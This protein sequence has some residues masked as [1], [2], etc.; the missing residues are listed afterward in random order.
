[1]GPPR[2]STGVDYTLSLVNCPLGS[3]KNV[4]VVRSNLG[5]SRFSLDLASGFILA[6]LTRVLLL[7]EFPVAKVAL[8]DI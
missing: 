4:G 2:T 7:E 6:S 5:D 1:M 8:L 3:L